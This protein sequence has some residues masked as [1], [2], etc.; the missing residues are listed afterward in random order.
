MEPIGKHNFFNSQI[1][2]LIGK[3]NSF[4]SQHFLE[5]RESPENNSIFY[6]KIREL[7]RF[8]THLLQ[9][10]HYKGHKIEN[11]KC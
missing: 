9:P 8:A 10:S 2:E 11:Q 3:H 6:C 5:R 4:N 7:L 1:M